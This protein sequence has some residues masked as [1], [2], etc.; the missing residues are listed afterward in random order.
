MTTSEAP[1][2]T[3]DN[4]LGWYRATWYSVVWLLNPLY[5]MH[6]MHDALLHTHEYLKRILQFG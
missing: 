4:A 2:W 5:P 3:L 6:Y 1:T